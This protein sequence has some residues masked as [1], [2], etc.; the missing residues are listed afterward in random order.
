VTG[1]WGPRGLRGDRV[2]G[3]QG[4]RPPRDP[5]TPRPRDP[6]V[7][8]RQKAWHRHG[9]ERP[10]PIE[11]PGRLTIEAF[12]SQRIR[13]PAL[14]AQWEDDELSAISYQLSAISQISP[15]RLTD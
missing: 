5:A 2:A 15:D 14:K 10:S 3:W 12:K 4:E 6:P 7:V 13:A 1:D 11:T 8:G 9:L